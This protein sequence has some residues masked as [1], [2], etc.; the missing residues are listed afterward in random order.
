MPL[1]ASIQADWLQQTTLHQLFQILDGE[2]KDRLRLVGGCVRDS[3]LGQAP[4]EIDLATTWTPDE[5][6]Q[7]CQE[8]GVKAV[9]TGYDHGTVTVI[10]EGQPFEVTTLRADVETD[11]RHAVVHFGQSW[12]EDAARRDLTINALYAD[13]AGRVYDP[14]GLGLADLKA[15]RVRFIGEAGVRLAEDALRI[16]RYFRFYT[17]FGKGAPDREALLAIV[18]HRPL[19]DGL[20]R[21]RVWDEL[22]KLMS[23]ANPRRGLLWMKQS[24]VLD[25]ILPENWGLDALERVLKLEEITKT[26]ADALLRLEALLPPFQDKIDALGSRLK[27]SNKE[28]ARLKEWGDVGLFDIASL[29]RTALQ[30]ELYWKGRQA[31]T[32]RLFLDLAKY[33]EQM[34]GADNETCFQKGCDLLNWAREWEKPVFPLKGHDLLKQGYKPGPDLGQALR[35]KEQ[36]WV[37]EGFP[38][39]DSV[40]P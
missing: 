20:S 3:L 38:P 7:L 29:D 21:E 31:V 17:R 28:K 2:G 37:A 15:G 35:E 40:T 30:K 22:K 9:P 27:L 10:V 14:L 23:V 1:P 12:E 34:Q 19:L 8:K 24:G 25:H 32:D 16:M 11:G 13:H 5:V 26:Q 36:Q 39:L 33:H 4:H 18:R 6:L